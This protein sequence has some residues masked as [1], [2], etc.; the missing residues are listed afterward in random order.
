[1]R[2]ILVTGAGGPASRNF[3]ESLKMND[4]DIYIVGIDINKYHLACVD[5]NKRYLVPSFDSENYI[6]TINK[7]IKKENIH[8]IHAQPDVEVEFIATHKNDIKANTFL[9]SIEA[10]FKCRN[11]LETYLALRDKKIP[12][13]ESYLVKKLD[14]IDTI[15]KKLPTEVKWVRAVKGAGSRAALPVKTT[16]QAR[17]WINYWREMKDLESQDF[18]IC[19]FLPGR[20]FAWQ[21]VWTD[22]RLVTSMARER[23]EYLFGNLTVS[24]QSSSPSIAQ[25][26]HYDRLNM[27][28]V[29]AVK[30][31]DPKPQGIYCVDIKEN[32]DK[33]P[34]VTEINAGRFFTTS[35]FFSH[36]GSN[37]P[38]I[39]VRLAFGED[40]E[41]LKL[42]NSAPSKLYWIR[43][44]DRKPTLLSEDELQ[45]RIERNI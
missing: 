45:K 16:Q 18:M 32:Y 36:I 21:S 6:H 4:F 41:P 40:I 35:N 9:P 20:E 5:V 22:G 2:R 14:N 1:M 13:P 27:I 34:C 17:E 12:V 7:I 29:G 38:Q 43:G 37:M 44:V 11:K 31:V 30:A 28:G 39:Y 24:G 10:I 8:L 19:E 23:L 42:T 3:I 33:I 26:L 15:M 25:S